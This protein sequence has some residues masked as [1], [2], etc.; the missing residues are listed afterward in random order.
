MSW[1]LIHLFISVCKHVI[2][3]LQSFSRIKSYEDECIWNLQHTY[4]DLFNFFEEIQKFNQTVV[5]KWPFFSSPFLL[6]WTGFYLLS[7]CQRSE[8]PPSL[9]LVYI[10][11]LIPHPRH[12]GH[13]DGGS[14]ILQNVGIHPQDSKQSLPC[15]LYTTL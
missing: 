2:F 6:A 12:F 3:C 14:T 5:W 10:T 11:Q 15:F 9:H 4:I 1:W 7:P 8:W 13:E